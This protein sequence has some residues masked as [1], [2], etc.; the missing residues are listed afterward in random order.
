[1]E[2]LQK[3]MKALKIYSGILTMLVL[4]LIVTAFR[5]NNSD[6]EHFK[7]I[8]AERIDIVD[9]NGQI[10]MAISNHDRQHP[11]T[12]GGKELPKRDRP[13]GMIFFNDD[14]DECGGLVYDG[15]KKGAGMVY[16]IDQYLN[17]QIM[18]LQYNQYNEGKTMQRSYGFKLW[19][20]YDNYP[21][22]KV[23]ANID[24]LKKLKD[25]AAYNAGIKKLQQPGVITA[26]RLF[27]GKNTKGE[28]G[29]FLRDDKGKP[30][31]KIY[32][33]SQ[34]QPVMETLNDKGE[35]ITSK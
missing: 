2:N 20:K 15:N 17:D 1:M 28:V 10:R 7:H 23:M 8:T 22:T 19:D 6:N 11:G 27:V 14:G 18:Q 34:N 25:T 21:S 12:L 3:Q 4:V 5:Q 29:L 30:R 13:A 32:I 35:V 9:A 24:S 33:N 16:S 26:E 31:L